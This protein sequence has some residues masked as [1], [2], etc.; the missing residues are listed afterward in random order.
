MFIEYW[1]SVEVGGQWFFWNQKT[2]WKK[3]SGYRT[4]GR[5]QTYRFGSTLG[6]PSC[7]SKPLVAPE[8]FKEL[9]HLIL[10]KTARVILEKYLRGHLEGKDPKQVGS[11]NLAARGEGR[12]SG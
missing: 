11:E 3:E 6:C 2:D 8:N 4:R 7:H 9:L 5:H 12:G 10:R 1:V